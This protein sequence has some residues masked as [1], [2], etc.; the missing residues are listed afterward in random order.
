MRA[1]NPQV[2]LTSHRWHGPICRHIATDWWT[3]GAS[4]VQGHRRA[5]TGRF[6][7][8]RINGTHKL[9]IG[10]V[11]PVMLTKPL[12]RVNLQAHGNKQ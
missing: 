9:L 10:E 1:K 6:V 11:S 5:R 4:N 12:N 2:S 8:R 3:P 7:G